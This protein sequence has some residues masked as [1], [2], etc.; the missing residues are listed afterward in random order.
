[1]RLNVELSCF[2]MTTLPVLKHCWTKS[3]RKNRTNSCRRCEYLNKLTF[4]A[5]VEERFFDDGISIDAC[6]GEALAKGYFPRENMLCT[7]TIYNYIDNGLMLIHNHN[8]PEKLSRKPKYERVNENK[9]YLGALLRK[10]QILMT[11]L[12]SGIGKQI[13]S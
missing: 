5:Y 9:K 1:M 12:N 10:G 7:K 2:T 13:L 6:V 8:L 11:D 3:V 4:I